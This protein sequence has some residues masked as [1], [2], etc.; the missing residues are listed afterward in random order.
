M[1]YEALFTTKKTALQFSGGKDSLAL[2]HLFKPYL[3]LLTVYYTN[4]GDAFP[5]TLTSVEWAKTIAPN[6]VEIE[7]RRQLVEKHFGWA[8][9]LVTAGSTDIGHSAGDQDP[10]LI[11]RYSCCFESMMR[12]MFERMMADGIEVIVR[13]QKN[14]DKHKG[15]ARSGDVAGPILLLYPLEDWSDEVVFDYLNTHSIPLPRFY[16]GGMN[17][18]GDCLTCTGWL[19]HNQMQYLRKHHPEA[20]K[21]VLYRINK[22]KKAVDRSYELL[23]S[24]VQEGAE[25]E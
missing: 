21:V 22:I 25:Q 19:E 15:P 10:K 1:N 2:L 5:E 24:A 3:H 9:D 20:A 16:Q 13:G 17:S 11:D 23:A 8:T 14:D 6:F 4:A 7:G 12:P 18:G